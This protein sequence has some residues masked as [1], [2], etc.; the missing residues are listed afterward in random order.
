MFPDSVLSDRDLLVARISYKETRETIV[1][2]RQQRHIL[3]HGVE[4]W[5]GVEP[6][7]GVVFLE[8]VFWSQCKSFKVRVRSE[9]T[10]LSAT[11]LTL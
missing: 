2:V 7:S 10:D 3:I 5:S 9:T 6:W 8:L 4:S 11:P 1:T